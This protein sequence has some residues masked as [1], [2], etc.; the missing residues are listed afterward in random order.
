ML[1]RSKSAK[2]LRAPVE[3][4]FHNNVLNQLLKSLQPNENDNLQLRGHSYLP[5]IEHQ[6]FDSL[7]EDWK[8]IFNLNLPEFDA[9]HYLVELCAFHVMLYQLNTATW[10]IPDS[11]KVHFICEVIAPKKDSRP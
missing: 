1:T 11:R 5:Y 2:V 10:F 4:L 6:C 9:Y 8:S 7:G 3:S